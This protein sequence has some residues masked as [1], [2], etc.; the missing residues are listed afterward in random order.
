MRRDQRG[1]EGVES[2]R[3]HPCLPAREGLV[4]RRDQLLDVAACQRRDVDPRRPADLD[5]FAIDLLLEIALAILVH[6]VPLVVGDHEGSTGLDDEGE[7]TQVLLAQGLGGVHEDESDL[8]LLQRRSGAQARVILVA[9]GLTHSTSNAGRVDEPPFAIPEDDELVHRIHRGPGHRVHDDARLPSE[10]VEQGGLA[11][12]GLA[13]QRHAA[14]SA[15]AHPTLALLG[16]QGD[17]LVQE[18]TAS[19]TVQGGDGMRFAESER[20]QRSSI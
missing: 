8:G 16:E 19:P 14:G 3:G 1:E 10:L 9:A 6:E 12:I 20:P 18:V 7:E 2:R 17:D 5:E 4:Q 13:Q 11:H 15:S